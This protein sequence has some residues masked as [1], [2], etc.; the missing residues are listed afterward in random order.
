MFESGLTKSNIR[1]NIEATERTDVR[2]VAR[3]ETRGM[4][5]MATG[6]DMG[7]SCV[8]LDV[9]A[10]E[11]ADRI[12]LRS[13]EHAVA[14]PVRGW[15]ARHMRM[16]V[17]VLLACATSF[18]LWGSGAWSGG[19]SPAAAGTQA[20]ASDAADAA[21]VHYTVRS[22]DTLWS[23]ARWCGYANAQ[24]GVAELMALNDLDSAALRPGQHLVLPMGM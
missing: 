20:T 11:R 13:G 17:I 2:K 3:M 14:A 8:V 23:I 16:L 5:T 10:P 12:R 15:F 6:C 18:A 19:R 9:P 4:W 7:R 21:V 1:A 22:G 24:D